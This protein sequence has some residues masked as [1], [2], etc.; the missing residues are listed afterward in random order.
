MSARRRDDMSDASTS[1]NN[2]SAGARLSASATFKKLALDRFVLTHF[3]LIFFVSFI[4]G[5][6]FLHSTITL[7]QWS[8]NEDTIMDILQTATNGFTA[9]D[10]DE[11]PKM[12]ITTTTVKSLVNDTK[13]SSSYFLRW[14]WW[15]LLWLL[16]W[17]WLWFCVDCCGEYSGQNCL[18]FYAHARTN[19]AG[20]F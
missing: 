17:L 3:F 11:Q 18:S 13:S 2:K 5:I 15:L 7:W 14:S 16:L 9:P 12:K 6:V 8:M 1:Q 10:K 20:Y 4:I 19:S